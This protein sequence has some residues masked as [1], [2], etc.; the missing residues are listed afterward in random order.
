[1]G[2]LVLGKTHRPNPHTLL[3]LLKERAYRLED[4]QQRH[5]LRLVRFLGSNCRSSVFSLN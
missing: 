4:P 5:G 2:V 3:G 1:M